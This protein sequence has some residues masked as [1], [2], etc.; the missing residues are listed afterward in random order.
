LFTPPTRAS[1]ACA[2][3]RREDEREINKEIRSKRR[4]RRKRRPMGEIPVPAET[5]RPHSQRDGKIEVG[6]LIRTPTGLRPVLRPSKRMDQRRKE[7]DHG[8]EKGE[9]ERRTATVGRGRG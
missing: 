4:T 6:T 9:E 3:R 7:E 2:P 1:A 8:E 5:L